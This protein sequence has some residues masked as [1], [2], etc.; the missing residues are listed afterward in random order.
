M[1]RSIL[2]AILF[3]TVALT[4]C[5][6][7]ASSLPT[8]APTPLPSP[9]ALPTPITVPTATALPVATPVH[10]PVVAQPPSPV[11]SSQIRTLVGAPLST[12]LSLPDV[13]ETALLSVVEIRTPA[14]NTGTGFIV[15][16]DG[17]VITNNHVVPDVDRVNLR[18]V[19]GA[20]YSA[21]VTGRH[22]T[23]DLAYLEITGPH[24]PLTPI[25]LGNSDAVRVGEGV[26]VIGF[27]LGADLGQDPTVSQGIVSAI[28]T[29]ALQTDAPVNPGNS[30]GPMLD[31]AGNVVGVVSSRAE[32]T[33]DGRAV[34][35]IGFAIPIN[36]AVA[37]LAAGGQAQPVP[38][39]SPVPS[40]TAAPTPMPTAVP[41]IPPTIDL[42]ATKA[43]IDA[44]NARLQTRTAVQQENERAAQEAREY[45]RSVEATRVANLPTATPEP[46]PTPL[47]TATP[48][49]RIYCQEW[50]AMVLAWIYQG[51]NY[52]VGPSYA[53]FPT[54]NPDVP[55]H[56]NL[57]AEQANYLCIIAFPRGRFSGWGDTAKKTVGNGAGQQL[58]GAYQYI[59][60]SGGN[61]VEGKGCSVILNVR[62][63]NRSDVEM[64]YGEPFQ[65]DLFTYHNEVSVWIG[66][67]Y[68]CLG[69][70]Y[71]VGS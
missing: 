4:A 63:S 20:Q 1:I 48:H 53:R 54:P 12:G 67:D 62:E 71:R 19:S 25:A 32:T 29:G 36:A 69:F 44:E 50:E 68:P 5:N 9:T 42:Q 8:L 66:G 2:A 17:Q 38:T 45:A 23:L 43:A 21:Q 27:P 14:G 30:G 15:T 55:D 34:P 61:R 40:A 49:P 59:A 6:A 65:I 47:P 57:S 60:S 33:N 3:L 58:P 26:I 46:T 39:P 16:A 13:V 18:L 31:H 35:G 11:P 41:P 52:D 37:G 64:V 70:L 56:P 22:S 10:T 51:N 7:P 28:R 24:G